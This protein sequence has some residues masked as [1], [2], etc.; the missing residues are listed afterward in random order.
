MCLHNGTSIK[1]PKCWASESFQVGEHIKVWER[2]MPP[3]GKEALHTSPMP[4]P[5]HLFH[6]AV[7][8]LLL[9]DKP[10]IVLKVLFWV[11]W[12][13]STKLSNLK[14]WVVETS[15]TLTSQPFGWKYRWP[16][17]KEWT[18]IQS[19]KSLWR[20]YGTAK[21]LISDS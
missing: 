1:T 10:V 16:Q 21:T 3:E 8:E 9:Y 19:W 15:P 13:I 14:G 17:V 4:C 20:E 18:T 6:Q 5:M 12:A 2:S 7:A 11:L